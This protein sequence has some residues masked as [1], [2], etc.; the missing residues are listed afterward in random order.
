MKKLF[1]IGTLLLSTF[2]F[3]NESNRYVYDEVETTE[4]ES[5]AGDFPAGPG[6]PAPIDQYIPVL[7]LAAVGLAAF[8][9]KKKHIS[10]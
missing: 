1:I 7:V 2:A 10:E 8:Y 9:G 5:L 4:D 3:S 6:D